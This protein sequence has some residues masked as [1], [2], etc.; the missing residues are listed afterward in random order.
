MEVTIAS[1]GIRP[2][3]IIQAIRP[4]SD[5]HLTTKQ[6][7][8][9]VSNPNRM[10]KTMRRRD[11]FHSPFRTSVP[12][13]HAKVLYPSQARLCNGPSLPLLTGLLVRRAGLARAGLGLQKTRITRLP[14]LW[15][16][17][18][19]DGLRSCSSECYVLYILPPPYLPLRC[20][21]Q[22]GRPCFVSPMS[23]LLPIMDSEPSTQVPW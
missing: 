1:L 17:G 19:Q 16:G 5:A 9:L 11:A 6:L 2:R 3:C 14:K 4:S 18:E 12:T 8:F 7:C 10:P 20:T 15:N 21:V 22:C 13:K 23:A